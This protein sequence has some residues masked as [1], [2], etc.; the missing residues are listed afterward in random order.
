MRML[1]GVFLAI[2]VLRE[3]CSVAPTFL[4]LLL[5]TEYSY[6]FLYCTS[7]S[8]CNIIHRVELGGASA[9]LGDSDP[10]IHKLFSPRNNIPQSDHY[11][12]AQWNL[13][14]PA[15]MHLLTHPTQTF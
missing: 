9:A 10:S 13:K 11:P 1:H 12:D 8:L 6:N 5:A 14:V 4:S 3:H 2:L 7:S 15:G